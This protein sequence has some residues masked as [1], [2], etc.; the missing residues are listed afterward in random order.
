[1]IHKNFMHEQAGLTAR[2][3]RHLPDLPSRNDSAPAFTLP[4]RKAIFPTDEESSTNPRARSARLRVAVRTDA[5]M[6]GK[7]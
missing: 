2:S 5:P 1:M 3:S 6:G 4:S 7:A